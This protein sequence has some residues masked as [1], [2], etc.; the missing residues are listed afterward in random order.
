MCYN[1][2]PYPER[3]IR[4]KTRENMTNLVKKI[5]P[6]KCRC[7]PLEGNRIDADFGNKDSSNK[8]EK[9]SLSCNFNKATK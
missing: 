3:A 9:P 4:S 7:Q 1:V 2:R 6:Y 8:N 5:R